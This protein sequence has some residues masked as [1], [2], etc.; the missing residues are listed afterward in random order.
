MG[1]AGDSLKSQPMVADLVSKFNVQG[2]L[3]GKMFIRLNSANVSRSEGSVNLQLKKATLLIDQSLGMADQQFEKALVKASFK[4]G[5][6]TVDKRS[7]FHTQELKIDLNGSVGIKKKLH[8]SSLNLSLNVK[9]E[10]GLKEQ[11][12]YVIDNMLGGNGGLLKY[13]IKGTVS[14]PN[15]V[16][17]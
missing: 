13:Q 17:L 3:S 11:Y 16:T 12:G 7:G 15:F 8:A 9:L 1:V 5:K 10:K 6:L 2:Y 4:S 14:K